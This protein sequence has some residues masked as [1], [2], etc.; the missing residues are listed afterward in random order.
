[1]EPINQLREAR[2]VKLNRIKDLG[3]KPYPPFFSKKHSVVNCREM[4]E[5]QVTTAGRL[6]SLRPH[7][8]II[9]ADLADESGKIQLLF[10]S[11]N[12]GEEKFKFLELL[13]LGDFLGVVGKVDKT[14]TGELTIIVEAYELLSKALRPIP[15]QWYGLKDSEERYRKR[16]LDFILNPENKK[17]LDI[18]WQMERKIREFLWGK[19]FYEVETPVLQNLYGGTNAKP[20]TT[21]LN[22]LD[23]KMYLRVAPELYLKRLI[24]AGYERIFEIAR[25][26]RNEGMDHSHQPEFTMLEWYIAYSDYHLVMDLAEEMTK[27]LCAEILGTQKLTLGG[28]TIDVSGSWPR[29]T[30]K[31]ALKIYLKIDWEQITDGQIQN[32]LDKEK[33]KIAGVW[34]KNKALFALY[35]HLVTPKLVGPVWVIDYPREVSPLS[36]EHRDSPEEF[37]ER[38]EGYIGGEEIY[39]G[40]SEI[41]SGLEQ[42]DRFE[43]EQ[44]NL[45]AGDKEAQPLDEDFIEALE[46]GMPPLGG[47]GF[48]IDRLAML[49]TNT[50][51]IRDV[52][53]FPLLRPEGHSI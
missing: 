22:A 37:V 41:T 25:N 7:G 3:V 33:I 27:Y 30:V 44:K 42:R 12:L 23:Q 1:M 32:I 31:E 36:K 5:K 53:S 45:K 47:I 51:N 40:W 14:K 19:G 28:K 46:Y 38:F 43:N 6:M 35:D 49:L 18:R 20:F 24:V 17:R 21:H 15:S 11:N 16:Y 10:R 29:V 52:I 34:S 26:F 13:D 8:K 4:L 50:E 9:F 39:D 48:G 2:I